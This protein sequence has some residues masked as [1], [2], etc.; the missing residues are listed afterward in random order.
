M[1]PLD[2]YPIHQVPI[3]M[4]Y[5]ATSDRN[6]YDRC[7][8]H[9]LDTQGSA[10]MITGLGV[11]PNLGVIDAYATVRRGDEQHAIRMSGPLP[12]D[13]RSQQVGPYR[14]EVVEPFHKLR[15]VCD[16]DEHGIG[17]DLLY[18]SEYG[19]IEEPQH[20][21]RQ[22]NRV[23]LDASRFAGVGTWA[24]ELRVGG[25][26]ITVTPDRFVATRDRSWGIR[27]IGESEPPGK[28]RVWEG[29]W[30]CWV[31]LRFADFGMH[32]MVEESPSGHR[33]TNFAVRVWPEE[34][35]RPPEQLGWPLPQIRYRSGTR[36]PEEATFGL[37]DRHGETHMLSVETVTGIPLNVGCGYGGDP[38]WTHGLWKGDG[39][40]EGAV[41]SYE[42]PVVAARVPLSVTDHLAR[43]VFD[44]QPGWGVFEHATIGRHDPSGFPDMAA[45]AP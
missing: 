40:V 42:D 35:G 27:P 5:T 26:T 7:I 14:I 15:L 12:A 13:R 20:F 43:A 1:D 11:Y 33:T 32:L 36:H 17:F 8:F 44:G 45:V 2:E 23:L 28:P 19:P 9:V 29:M 37:T 34:A 25:D 18:E 4:Q 21:R 22:G 10:M 3:S 39:W 41:Y 31:P 6:F 38:D 16:G 24:G 30:W